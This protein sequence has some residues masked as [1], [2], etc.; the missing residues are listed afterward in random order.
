MIIDLIEECMIIQFE[1][2]YVLFLFCVCF[3]VVM[4]LIM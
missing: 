1:F 3:G 4:R 2:C